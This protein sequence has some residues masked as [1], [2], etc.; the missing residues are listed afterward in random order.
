MFLWFE[1]FTTFSSS[2][3]TTSQKL[4][5]CIS[6]YMLLNTGSTRFTWSKGPTGKR[7][8]TRISGSYFLFAFSFHFISFQ[9]I[10]LLL[11]SFSF[12]LNELFCDVLINILTGSSW[13]SRA[14]WRTWK[15]R[16]RRIAW[17]TGNVFD[18][19]M[20]LELL[21]LQFNIK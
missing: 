3:L 12:N 9:I 15:E 5:N 8:N 1:F 7:R 17:T 6:K 19:Y 10:C 11:T 2:V 13:S 14:T 16:T 4:A 20:N 18:E 21:D